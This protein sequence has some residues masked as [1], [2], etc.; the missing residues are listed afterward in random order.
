MATNTFKRLTKASVSNSSGSPSTIYTAATNKTSIVIGCLVC[1]K[2]ATQVTVTVLIDTA[3]SGNDDVFLV[4]DL[5][6]PGN[7]STEL[8]LGKVILSH[9]NS[10]GDVLKAYSNTASAIDILASVLEDVN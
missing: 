2:L 5:V 6:V 9:D 8:V 3:I 7:T 1:N 10:N 4:K